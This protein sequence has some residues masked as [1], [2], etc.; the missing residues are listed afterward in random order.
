MTIFRCFGVVLILKCLQIVESGR[1]ICLLLMEAY[2]P[3]IKLSKIYKS[4]LNIKKYWNCWILWHP[5][6]CVTMFCF[7]R[8][9]NY[10]PRIFLIQRFSIKKPADPLFC[11]NYRINVNFSIINDI[12]IQVFDRNPINLI[13]L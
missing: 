8:I 2:K 12:N 10:N 5:G 4:I 13:T 9:T 7:C 6:Y 3:N 1:K 11:L